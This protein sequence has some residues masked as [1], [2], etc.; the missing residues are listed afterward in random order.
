MP[1]EVATAQASS[2]QEE[3]SQPSTPPE[4]DLGAALQHPKM[5][6]H[7]EQHTQMIEKEWKAKL[8]ASAKELGV[9]RQR[10]GDQIK[11]LQNKLDDA[12]ARLEAAKLSEDQEAIARSRV[13][14]RRL[15]REA[16]EQRTA[17]EQTA[18]VL[19][20]R[21]LAIGMIIDALGIKEDVVAFAQQKLAQ[22]VPSYRISPEIKK[23]LPQPSTN[24]NGGIAKPDLDAALAGRAQGGGGE[25]VTADNIDALYLAGKVSGAAYN[26]FLKSGKLP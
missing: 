22:G 12:E 11:D 2:T 15:Q 14:L 8:D 13:Q 21:E 17:A 3:Q 26:T 9:T 7:L 6:A 23:M 1:E 24:G 5:Q 19:A 20:N 10:Q 4:F 25:R 18:T 16:E